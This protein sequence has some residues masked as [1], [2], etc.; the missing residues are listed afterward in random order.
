[1]C[2]VLKS[3]DWPACFIKNVLGLSAEKALEMT[4]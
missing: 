2:R 4:I 3:S 1:M